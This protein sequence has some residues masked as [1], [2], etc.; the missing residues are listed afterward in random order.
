MVII[1][2]FQWFLHQW[3][4]RRLL[5][6]FVI[7]D[8]AGFALNGAVNNHNVRKYAPANQPPDFHYSVS[9]NRQK[10]YVLVG[11]CWVFSSLTETLMDKVI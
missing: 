3:N 11:L 4:N 9:D 10:L 7:G 5:A 2:D 8:E 6:N 1:R